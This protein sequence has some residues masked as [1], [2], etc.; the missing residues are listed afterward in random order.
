MCGSIEEKDDLVGEREL[1]ISD[2]EGEKEMRRRADGSCSAL[3][4]VGSESHKRE[5]SLGSGD[6][7]QS[8][9]SLNSAK[10]RER[11]F[12]RISMVTYERKRSL[13][14]EGLEDVREM[15]L[16]K[17]L[18]LGTVIERGRFGFS[19]ENAHSGSVNLNFL[20]TPNQNLKKEQS[21][22]QKN[23]K[24]EEPMD[25]EDQMLDK[26]LRKISIG[27]GLQ[28]IE[29]TE[30][31]CHELG[32]VSVST[33]IH[34]QSSEM[35]IKPLNRLFRP[36]KE[37]NSKEPITTVRT[38]ENEIVF[39]ENETSEKLARLFIEFREKLAT[40]SKIPESEKRLLETSLKILFDF[41]IKE[42]EIENLGDDHRDMVRTFIRDRFFKKKV[43]G[44][45]NGGRKRGRRGRKSGGVRRD[46]S[47]KRVGKG[48]QGLKRVKHSN[49]P[50]T[51]NYD[52]KNFVIERKNLRLNLFGFVREH[53]DHCVLNRNDFLG[54]K[55]SSDAAI[56][57][58]VKKH[59]R[60]K[61]KNSKFNCS[62]QKKNLGKKERVDLISNN[63]GNY[64]KFGKNEGS[65]SSMVAGRSPSFLSVKKAPIPVQQKLLK[66]RSFFKFSSDSVEVDLPMIES[67][68]EK[69]D[70]VEL[71]TAQKYLKMKAAIGLLSRSLPEEWTRGKRNDE[72]I[73]KIFKKGMKKLLTRFRETY[74]GPKL[75]AI[76][77]EEK[78]YQHYF[79]NLPDKLSTFY[80]PL[81]KRVKN[82]RFRSISNDYLLHL[83]QSEHFRTEMRNYCLGEMVYDSLAKYP[84]LLMK[85][86][87]ENSNFLEGQ[88]KAKSKFEWARHE[89]ASAVVLF[90]ETFDRSKQEC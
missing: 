23:L 57:K 78:F 10:S 79:G 32:S 2:L 59:P 70:S 31:T 49:Q 36:A 74:P 15:P 5:R 54:V 90:L 42:S 61:R 52:S 58:T 44:V 22:V 1:W 17:E 86:Y 50:K 45:C 30:E 35:E 47:F 9:L 69:G 68:M 55:R 14:F 76:K 82:P 21:F 89:M 64:E 81:K 40:E 71:K 33:E 75:T 27:D 8:N 62:T 53:L 85:R 7:A 80:D 25:L 84:A 16:K 56:L 3:G 77:Y 12:D 43:P 26:N 60:T 48:K 13:G 39:P 72:K 66:K 46:K 67:H 88:Y 38:L 63:P 28:K 73:K 6:A 34:D 51:L 37:V 87:K 19:T 29:G 41:E 11:S 20:N 24:V 4:R 65:G 83:K 18:S